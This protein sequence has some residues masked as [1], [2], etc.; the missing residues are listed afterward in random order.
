MV[1]LS[2]RKRTDIVTRSLPPKARRGRTSVLEPYVDEIMAMY[3]RESAES[4][5]AHLEEKYSIK[6]T[7]HAVYKF[8]KT[9]LKYMEDES[10]NKEAVSPG[11]AG[12]KKEVSSVARAEKLPEPEKHE[13][14]EPESSEEREDYSGFK[15]KKRVERE[16]KSSSFVD[17][18]T[19]SILS[20]IKDK[21]GKKE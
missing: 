4:I 7:K 8:I 17:V 20:G 19:N 2:P 12:I 5:R 11:K 9:R 3:E 10:R 6:I 15:S 18:E 14:K 1:H 21:S 13:R 16:R